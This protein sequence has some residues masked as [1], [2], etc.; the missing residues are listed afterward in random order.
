MSYLNQPIQ[1][2]DTIQFIVFAQKNGVTW[3]ITGG[4]VTLTLKKPN[5]TSLGPYS[6]T[7]DDPT[8]G[9]AS[10]TVSDTSV[11]NAAGI[12]QL[13]WKIVV[14]SITM[15]SAIISFKVNANL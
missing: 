10:Y 11:I 1:I 7:L 5:G 12:W 8:A 6:A 4:T 13:Q 14:G 2:G 9:E 15:R 3:D